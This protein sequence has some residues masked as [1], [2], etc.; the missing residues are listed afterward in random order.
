MAHAH[1]L[2]HRPGIGCA[3]AEHD[4]SRR[5]RRLSNGVL[6]VQAGLAS[7]SASMGRN[8]CTPTAAFSMTPGQFCWWVTA[9]QM[10][11]PGGRAGR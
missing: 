5:V 8:T 9:L 2:N 11:W 3:A 6:L 10:C 7:A 1:R 4:P